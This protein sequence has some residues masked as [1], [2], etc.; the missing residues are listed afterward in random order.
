MASFPADEE[1]NN[2]EVQEETNNDDDAHLQLDG[3]EEE[4]GVEDDG[5]NVP[6]EE[7]IGTECQQDDSTAPQQADSNAPEE[8]QGDAVDTA[9]VLDAPDALDDE[10][11]R[12]LGYHGQTE[13][14]Q[15]DDDV[16][17]H[18]DEEHKETAAI[19]E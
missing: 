15:D 14:H 8:D 16:F 19:L 9:V 13:L 3:E 11:A 10:I 18:K 17:L 6:E 12:I 5:S 1:E 7:P 2:A 4:Q